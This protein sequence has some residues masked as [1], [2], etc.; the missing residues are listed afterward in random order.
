MREVTGASRPSR[1]SDEHAAKTG[2]ARP[3]LPGEVPGVH[4]HA[5]GATTRSTVT[6]AARGARTTP[7]AG[8]RCPTAFPG[9]TLVIPTGTR[10]GPGQR[11]RLPVPAGQRLRLPDRRPRPGQRAGAAPDGSGHDAVLYTR[12]RSSRETDEFFRSRDGELWV[13]RRHTL[14]REGRPSWA[15]RPRRWPTWAARWPTARRAAP[16]CCAASTRR[17]TRG[18]GLRARRRGRRRDRELARRISELQAGQGRVGDRPA[19]GR[20]R[21]DRARLRGRGPGPAGRPARSRSGCSRASS[22]CAPATTATTSAT[23][24]SSAPARTRR[25][26]TGSA[27]PASP[28][29]ASCC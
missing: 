2:V 21:R 1:P 15:S 26:C 17:S 27:T 14:G 3:G 6:P 8:P 23:A 11:H 28:A 16:G 25:S 19:A 22:G 4:A 12:P 24:R 13:G 5:A 29:R 18:A 7:S 20:D 9:E 10:E